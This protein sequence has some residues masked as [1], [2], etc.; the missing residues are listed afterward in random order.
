MRS[1]YRSIDLS[2]TM[3][4]TLSRDFIHQVYTP[5]PAI[6]KPLFHVLHLYYCLDLLIFSHSIQD[7]VF[8]ISTREK[9]KLKNMVIDN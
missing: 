1:M 5:E 8:D 9:K 7:T 2:Y 3:T 4:T 6:S